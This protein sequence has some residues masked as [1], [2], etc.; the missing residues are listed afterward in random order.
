MPITERVMALGN[1][2][3]RLR[4]DTPFGLR[5][6]IS[7]PL[8]TLVVTRNY[9]P[10]AVVSDSL[11]LNAGNAYSGVVLRPG[12]QLE[13]GGCGLAWFLGDD[14]GGPGVLEAGL[15]MAQGATLGSAMA[16]VLSGTS[17]LSGTI[18]AGSVNA[19]DIGICTTRRHVLNLLAQSF[20]Y[21]WRIKAN[22]Y[23]DVASPTTIYGATPTGV[24]VKEHG[25]QEVN[26]PY[27]IT[28]AVGS[29]WDWEQ[30][31]SKAYVF[32]NV[33]YG[34]S[35]GASPY[36][37]PIGNLMTIVRVFEQ[38]DAYR[39]SESTIAQWW[40][41]Q[42]NRGVRSVTVSADD[43]Q[44]TGIVPCGGYVWLH[45]YELGLYDLANNVPYGG[46]MLHPVAARVQAV[47]WPVR[48][49]MGVYIRQ[50]N[51]TVVTYHDLTSYVEWESGSGQIEVSTSAQ[52]LAPPSQSPPLQTFFSPWQQYP[53]EW[54]ATT[55]N[56][57][58]G[59]GTITVSYRR[60]GTRLEI[61]GKITHGSTTTYGAGEW[62]VTLPAGCTTTASLGQQMGELL[63]VPTGA[64]AATPGNVWADQGATELRLIYWSTSTT[65]ASVTSAVPVTWGAG[66]YVTF[67]VTLEI[68]P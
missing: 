28:G 7:T 58:I 3:L 60:L 32:S 36:R 52:V 5:Q 27:G 19:W 20:N 49:G 65:A 30:Y 68:Q 57:T 50:H 59:N 10:A 25:P 61:N 34:S 44:V 26:T 6:S 46:G 17:F 21:E 40:V 41:G 14:S 24:I 31:G 13:I 2:S 53:A 56:P 23:I 35:G 64:V 11:A 38:T 39:A 29:T 9:I 15:S 1:W 47:T 51:G 37:D 8:A 54:R 12:P 66:T 33:G 42:I 22:R 45:D 48:E 63:C 43:Y 62:R 55:T 67:N 18:G 4:D 16:S